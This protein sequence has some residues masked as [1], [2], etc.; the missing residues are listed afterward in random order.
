MQ[1]GLQ[2]AQK[3]KGLRESLKDHQQD[4]HYVH[5]QNKEKKRVKKREDRLMHGGGGQVL[6]KDI[7]PS[8]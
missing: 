1:A 5:G 3:V 2:E 7:E 6:K 8:M 4:R